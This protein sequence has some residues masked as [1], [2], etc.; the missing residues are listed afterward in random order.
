MQNKNRPKFLNLMVLG[1]KMAINAKVSILH[2]ASGV[3]MVLAIP[4]F[5]YVLEQSLTSQ[6]FYDTLYGVIANPFIKII[7]LLLIWAFI[8]HMCSGVRFLFLDLHKGI[9]I[10]KAQMTARIVIALSLVFTAILGVL[11]W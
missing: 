11:V 10:K 8:Y 2:R 1:P 7:Y 9:E 6:S 3:L 4:F 5:L